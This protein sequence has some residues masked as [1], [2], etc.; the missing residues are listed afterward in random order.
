MYRYYSRRFLNLQGHHAGP[1]VLAIIEQLPKTSTRSSGGP[2][3]PAS[4]SP[5]AH[6]A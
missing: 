4:R 3:R 5:T 2:A 6:G 1:Y